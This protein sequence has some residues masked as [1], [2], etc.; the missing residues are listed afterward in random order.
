M[1][2]I[3]LSLSGGGAAGLGHIPVLEAFDDLGL[4]PVAIS[5]TSMGALIGAAYAAGLTAAEI[6]AHVL[7]LC[8]RPLVTARRFFDASAP[9]WKNFTLALDA[10]AAIRA[11]LPEGL[12]DRIEA[13]AIPFTAAITDYHGRSEM[14]R[15]RGNLVDI[16]AASIAIP[17]LFEPV[18]LEGRVCVDGGVINNLPVDALPEADLTLAV[19]AARELPQDRAD[20]PGQLDAMVGSMRIMMYAMMKEKIGARPGTVLIALDSAR[21]SAL[22]FEKAREILDAAAPARAETRAILEEHLD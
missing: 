17:G 21:Y 8:D 6:R 16:L 22:D 10:R 11:V 4:R 12:P 7:E 14:L 19:D 20:V 1:A 9:P 3:A 2:R 13:L 18:V 5:G 15:D